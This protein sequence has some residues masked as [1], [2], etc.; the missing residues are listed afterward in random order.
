MQSIIN[1]SVGGSCDF[2]FDKDGC[3]SLNPVIMESVKWNSKNNTLELKSGGSN[4][5]V[6][7]CSYSLASSGNISVFNSVG[8]MTFANGRLIG[9]PNG[10]YVNGVKIQPD[11]PA[12]QDSL[13]K[14]F[15]YKWSETGLPYPYS[16]GDVCALGSGTVTIDMP[17]ASR[18]DLS[19]Q[20]SGDLIIKKNNA[21][22]NCNVS[23]QGSGTIKGTGSIK[24][25]N[26][27]LQGSGD[28][29][30]FHITDK[31]KAS[32]QGS[33]DI[34]LTRSHTCIVSKSVSGSGDI[35]ISKEK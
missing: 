6:N 9:Q 21:Q 10:V 33:G 8:N 14:M 26:A 35:K 17:L 1:I 25:M 13:A 22:T 15:E 18:S 31:I 29:K 4:V 11:N 12:D 5:V 16:I 32:I 30:G 23:L 34:K 2:I 19:L 27:K 24:E 28:I 20:G 3:R 7:G